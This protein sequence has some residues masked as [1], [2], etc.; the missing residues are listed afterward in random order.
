MA[1]SI[2]RR[3]SWAGLPFSCS[4][5]KQLVLKTIF[6]TPFSLAAAAILFPKLAAISRS[7]TK[8]RCAAIASVP[9]AAL[10]IDC[11]SYRSACTVSTWANSVPCKA[12]GFRSAA[13]G[14]NP[15]SIKRVR[16]GWPW[17]P[18]A[19]STNTLVILHSPI[20]RL[21]CRRYSQR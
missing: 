11:A 21:T 12:S 8:G 6:L 19:P 18:V 20:G 2:S 16:R 14:V 4:A 10:I 15:A 9:C 5:T 3:P 1:C 7:K 17:S 13:T